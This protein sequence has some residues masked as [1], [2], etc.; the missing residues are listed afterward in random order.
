VRRHAAVFIRRDAIGDPVWL[1]EH[2]LL[3]SRQ[4]V[5]GEEGKWRDELFGV[6]AFDGVVA[7]IEQRG[8]GD[9]S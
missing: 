2:G 6:R 1:F 4:H 7:E 5:G 3:D 8:F 9:F